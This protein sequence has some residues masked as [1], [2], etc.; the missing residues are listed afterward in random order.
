MNIVRTGV[1]LNTENYEACVSIYRSVFELDVAAT[2]DP[3]RAYWQK[4]I[5]LA[6]F[7]G[8][9]CI[10]RLQCYHLR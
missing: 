5:A 4:F 7:S 10:T 6:A 2:D 8:A 9:T 1:I 3:R